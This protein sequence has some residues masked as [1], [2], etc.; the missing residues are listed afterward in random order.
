MNNPYLDFMTEI[1]T[2]YGIPRNLL[3][4]MKVAE[5]GPNYDSKAFTA[6]SGAGARG[7]MQFM[8]ETG[9]RYGLRSDD[10]FND[11]YKQITAAG[12]Y[13]KDII[14]K[15]INKIPLIAAAYNAGEN[16]PVIRAGRIP[17]NSE[18]PTY[19]QRVMGAYQPE[20]Q[21]PQSPMPQQ[22]AELVQA[23]PMSQ[24]FPNIWGELTKNSQNATMED[25]KKTASANQSPVTKVPETGEMPKPNNKPPGYGNMGMARAG[26]AGLA[27]ADQYVDMSQAAMPLLM[28]L[29]QLSKAMG[30]L[31][32]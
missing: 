20:Q 4:A 11:P 9:A 15:G 5:T 7:L 28:Q 27:G 19:V 3:R 25:A 10:D 21:L 14:A 16:H 13:I 17:Q 1:E 29:L 24:Q 32:A 6:K 2:K 8:P 22:P 18:T 31:N 12:Q 23:A 26:M 30:G